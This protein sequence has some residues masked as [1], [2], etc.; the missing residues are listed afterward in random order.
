MLEKFNSVALGVPAQQYFVRCH[1]TVERQIPVMTEFAVRL[2]HLAGKIEFEVFRQYF[3]LESHEANELLEILKAEG[4]VLDDE[5]F[6]ALTSYALARFVASSD[7]LPRFTKIE[8]R[9][10]Q[11]IFNLLT[12][13]PL[14]RPRLGGY[15]DNTLELYWEDTESLPAK[16][17]DQASEAFHRYFHDIEKIEKD[18]ENKRA[19]SV[20][21]IEEITSGKRFNVPIPIS[22]YLDAEGNV[23]YKLED[24]DL[25]PEELKSKL[26]QLTADRVGKMASYPDFFHEFPQVFDDIVLMRYMKEVPQFDS[27]DGKTL[28]LKPKP[29][30]DFIF[31]SYVREVHAIS[32]GDVYDRGQSQALLGALYMPQN[33][34]KLLTG[35][36]RSL[37]DFVLNNRSESTVPTELFWVIPE[38][39]LW[40]RTE[41]LKEAVLAISDL[42]QNE[43]KERVD[44]VAV[45]NSTQAVRRDSMLDK[46]RLLLNAGFDDVL[47][48]PSPHMSERFELLLLPSVHVAAMYQWKSPASEFLSVPIGFSSSYKS[49]LAKSLT[50]LRKVCS[51]KI[52]R[53]FWG[54]N[55]RI[56][57]NQLELIDLMASE[58]FYLDAF[59][60]SKIN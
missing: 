2:I 49:K 25:L 37:K 13:S 8:E 12:F 23:E 17:I 5:G 39:E 3:G 57:S 7:G 1:V 53:A 24:S 51:L 35:L 6:L 34:D 28:K 36:E 29:Q 21:K 60:E 20:Y 26:T 9:Q 56:E 38:N 43:W 4:L 15:W 31:Q 11:P 40:G 48:G 50:F 52:Y 19:Y 45:C 18:D 16:A 55:E 46:A 30:F 44:I 33:L 10:S 22:F 14:R 47:F 58:F 27:A 41:L 59:V 32:N 42:I 54:G